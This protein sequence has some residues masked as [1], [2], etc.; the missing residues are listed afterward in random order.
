MTQYLFSSV[1]ILFR[2]DSMM[3]LTAWMIHI[4]VLLWQNFAIDNMI[5]R[6]PYS[7]QPYLAIW[8]GVSIQ[9]NEQ[10]WH[11]HR[12]FPFRMALVLTTLTQSNYGG[13]FSVY[14][15]CTQFINICQSELGSITCNISILYH[16]I[17]LPLS[18]RSS[19]VTLAATW[20]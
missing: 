4:Q 18:Q 1:W 16:L 13:H 11:K 15:Q 6:L 3:Y 19:T 20:I 8:L 2:K 12:L 17:Y 5:G 14:Q 10:R 7:R 9:G